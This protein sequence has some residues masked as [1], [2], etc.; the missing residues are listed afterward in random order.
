[1][2]E[3]KGGKVE[4]QAGLWPEGRGVVR[5]WSQPPVEPRPAVGGPLAALVFS[6][7]Y[8]G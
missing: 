7:V 1:M 4:G 6:S 3:G 5:L 8:W 2:R